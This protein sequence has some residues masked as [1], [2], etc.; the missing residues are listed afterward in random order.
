[1]ST[2]AIIGGS[3]FLGRAL[4]RDLLRDHHDVISISREAYNS[5]VDDEL[6]RAIDWLK[7][8]GVENVIVTGDFHLSTQMVGADT[9]E[10][11]P[12][13]RALN[14]STVDTTSS[15][16]SVTSTSAATPSFI[17]PGIPPRHSRWARPRS[18]SAPTCFPWRAF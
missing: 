14:T 11:Y 13:S 2:V 7:G 5:D 10:F 12:R 4:C 15:A 1:M 17:S 9:S 18:K 16:H 8:A 3:G 6:N